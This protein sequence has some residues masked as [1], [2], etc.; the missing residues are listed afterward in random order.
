MKKRY[1]NW[2]IWKEGVTIPPEDRVPEVKGLDIIRS[3]FPPHLQDF[4]RNILEDL[5]QHGESKKDSIMDYIVDFKSSMRE[6]DSDNIEE[7]AKVVSANNLIKYRDAQ[8][9][10]RWAKG[11][12]YHIIGAIYYNTFLDVNNLQN[13]YQE[14]SEGDK[15]AFVYLKPNPYGFD[16]IAYP[17]DYRLPE[18][19][20]EFIY[21]Y[22]DRIKCTKKLLDKKLQT[23]YDALNWQ[24]PNE[25]QNDI[26]NI[27]L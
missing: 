9:P 12:P 25:N 5:L 11:T 23:Y 7:I 13:D 19:F 2:I 17:I 4:M 24:K 14:V 1:A 6:E 18:Q 10:R 15:I 8:N 16:R 21:Q 22:A 20:Y 3:D 26:S 27:F